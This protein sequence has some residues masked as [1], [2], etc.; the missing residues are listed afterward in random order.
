MPDFAVGSIQQSLLSQAQFQAV[1]GT[2]KWV[3]ANGQG[4]SG[5]QYSIITGNDNVP[6]F[7][8]CFIRMVGGE[9]DPLTIKQDSGVNINNTNINISTEVG[10]T[11]VSVGGTTVNVSGACNQLDGWTKYA[12]PTS[13]LQYNQGPYVL[14]GSND[15]PIKS[16]FWSLLNTGDSNRDNIKDY[17]H[18]GDVS[19]N[20]SG[21]SL[22]GNFSLSGMTATGTRV[23]ANDTRD[24]I[25][26]G[27]SSETRPKNVAM[28]FFI[29]IN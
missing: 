26:T 25:F 23:T 5:S 10:G 21:T 11:D 13:T 7:R 16:N 14:Y 29:K 12:E 27:D 20:H 3:L 4:A 19:H 17:T 9:A 2:T 24:G 18:Y 22:S 6:D 15:D 8:G 28:N 1:M